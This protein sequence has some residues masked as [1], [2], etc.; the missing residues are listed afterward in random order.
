MGE[1]P[2]RKFA[3]IAGGIVGLVL[4]VVLVA[5]LLID[6]N[7][8]KPQLVAQA[9]RA[10]G[11]DVAIEGPVRFAV[12]PV[13]R[14][15]VS[16]LRI[17][18][19]PGGRTP[20]MVD[21]KS[22][23][24]SLAVLP[25]LGL[26]FEIAELTLTEPNIALEVAADGRPNWLLG[27]SDAAAAPPPATSGVPPSGPGLSSKPLALHIDRIRIV[28]GRVSYTDARGG[29]PMRA[30]KVDLDLSAGG[31]EGPFA[32]KGSLVANGVP[33]SVDGRLGGRAERGHPLTL[34]LGGGGGRLRFDGTVSALAPDARLAGRLETRA[35]NLAAFVGSLASAALQPSPVLP[36][37]LAQKFSFDGVV[38]AGMAGFAAT[39][40]HVTLG[41]DSGQGS[42][43][44]ALRAPRRIEGNLAFK[45]LDLDRWLA[46]SS[47]PAAPAG[48]ARPPATPAP[49]SP[50]AAPLLPA[51]LAL[52][53]ALAADEVIYNGGTVRK[54]AVDAEADRG[55]LSLKRLEAQLPGDA[56]LAART[57]IAG[58]AARPQA[59]GEFSLAGPRL[60]ETLAWL[61]VDTASVPQGRLAA[62]SIKGNLAA[63]GDAIRVQNATFL[64]DQT[65]GTGSIAIVP[66]SP[67]S[68]TLL[69]EADSLDVDAYLPPRG[70]A[71][72]AAAPA[73]GSAARA[74]GPSG[75]G[76]LDLRLDAKLAHVV[77][78]GER[79]DGVDADVAWNGSRLTF[80]DT[81]VASLAG[82]AIAVRGTVTNPQS[83]PAFDLVV[84]V[85]SPDPARLAK[86]VGAEGALKGRQLGPVTAQ[87]GIAGTASELALRDLSV[88]LLGAKAAATGRL[89]LTPSGPKYNFS[90]F[91]FESADTARLLAAFSAGK[92][93]NL[94]AVKLNGSLGG[95]DDEVN[96]RGDANVRGVAASGSIAVQFGRAVPHVV[97]ELKAGELD[98]DKLVGVRGGGGA[99]TA[100]AQRGGGGGHFSRTPIDLSALRAIDGN[101]AIDSSAIILAPWRIDAAQVVLSLQGGLLTVA[102]LNGRTFGGAV[103]AS[104]TVDGSK[105]VPAF[106]V[107]L[108][109]DNVDMGGISRALAGGNRFDGT[110]DANFDVSGHGVSMADVVATLSGSGRLGG[111][112]RINASAKEQMAGTIAGALGKK[113][114][115]QI[116]KVLGGAVGGKVRE[117]TVDVATALRIA[118]DRFANRNGPAVASIAIRNGVASTSDLRLDGH[119][120]WALTTATVSLP[121][122]TI[123][124]TTNIHVAED[125]SQPCLIIRQ[126]GALDSPS[127][128]IDRGQSNCGGRRAESPALPGQQQEQ[129]QQ[130]QQQQREPQNP[131]KRQLRKIF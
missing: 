118:L 47:K 27:G 119:E 84:S 81:K 93:G 26:R 64:L 37:P 78:R 124:S 17:A 79:I 33:L 31:P 7:V 80:G 121:A 44:I 67:L 123:D 22:V 34:D 5:P 32:A 131:I 20:T 21:V 2:M 41:E 16:G 40:M 86:L 108:V 75:G 4:L 102:R 92:G 73:P 74:A 116:D 106:V 29:T 45:R 126:R 46:A 55:Q 58:D 95:D 76:G 88:S 63:S 117:E 10:T 109:A 105:N 111:S 23:D 130:Q 77:W 53:L 13:P 61:R 42:L 103:S 18:N 70:T 3:W 66:R 94:G 11:R 89:A 56:A 113:A 87:G 36:G 62:F 28:G 91:S 114:G 107:K 38:E 49:P 8:F 128:S 65:K 24:A 72:A 52:K 101:I 125:P 1:K 48:G 69:I 85:N 82:S 35:D 14:L 98:L 9:Q 83:T 57:S 50:A 51:D 97:A 43:S 68:V 19:P 96:F 115:K 99:A 6:G 54:L 12:L 129:Q 25:L 112:L 100:G 90:R 30:E 71:A 60:R 110:M 127:R 15:V 122:W 59:T 120:A 39:D 104:G